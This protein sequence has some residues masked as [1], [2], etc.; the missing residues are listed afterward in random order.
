MY[1]SICACEKITQSSYSIS[2][3]RGSRGDT[4][5]L[6]I[7]TSIGC[8][9]VVLILQHVTKR[10]TLKT[11]VYMEGSILSL[12]WALKPL[13]TQNWKLGI[14]HSKSPLNYKSHISGRL[15]KLKI[16]LIV[17]W[18]NCKNPFYSINT[19]KSEPNFVQ[20]ITSTHPSL[21]VHVKWH[22]QPHPK[23]PNLKFNPKFSK[24][25]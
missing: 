18:I 17:P 4:E 3:L 6:E 7:M 15:F 16:N 10:K 13:W 23:K 22:I 5:F 9:W 8:R 25:N 1:Q 14:N 21:K 12:I 20:V 2:L 11:K 24:L 19:T